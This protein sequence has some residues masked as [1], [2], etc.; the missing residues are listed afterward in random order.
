MGGGGAAGC[1][2]P[3]VL[4]PATS[5]ARGKDSARPRT[6]S[7]M[8]V[9]LWLGLPRRVAAGHTDGHGDAE[10]RPRKLAID[11]LHHAAMRCNELQYHRQPDAG[12]LDRGAACGAARVEG[13]EHVAPVLER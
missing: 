6:S 11:D 7:G 2:V 1:W 5:I 9:G 3:S 13:L 12:A 10:V 4:Q 8:G